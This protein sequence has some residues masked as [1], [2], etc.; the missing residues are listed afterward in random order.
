MLEK[1]PLA[2]ASNGQFLVVLV[3]HFYFAGYLGLKNIFKPSIPLLARLIFI[4]GVI[5]FSVGG[6]WVSSRHLAAVV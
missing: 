4:A 2:R 3:P 1:V 6:V 5:S